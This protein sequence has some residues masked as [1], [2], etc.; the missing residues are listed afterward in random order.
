MV[1]K[2]KEDD[3]THH[4]VVGTHTAPSLSTNHSMFYLED[5][6]Q[7]FVI[8]MSTPWPPTTYANT[9]ASVTAAGDATC[10]AQ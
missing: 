7:G 8:G 2:K 3:H 10:K 5:Y 1:D 6:W 4:P 9:T